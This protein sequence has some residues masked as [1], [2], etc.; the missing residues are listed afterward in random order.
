MIEIK[1]LAKAFA[2]G[3][4]SKLS[5]TEKQDVRYADK[6]F[7]SVRDVSFHCG[8][9]EV[10][11]LLGPNGAGK[12]T[13]LRMLSTALKPDA[14]SVLINGVDVLREPVKARKQIGFLSADTGL[15]GKLSAYENIAYF[16]RLHGMKEAALKQRIDELFTMLNMHDFASRRAD[17]MS[18][19]MKQKTAIARAVVHSP[20]VVILDEPT[21]GLD[22]MT[23]QTV[24]DFI[25]G[26]KQAGTPVIFSTHHLDEVASLCDRVVVIDKG[27]SAFSGDLAEFKALAP[28]GDLR[29]AFLSVLKQQPRE[30]GAA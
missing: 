16:G 20:K 3:K 1:N 26:L 30:Q 15:Y 24:L 6:E 27:I 23:V 18:T 25:K 5:E 17:N 14:G 13:T 12:T 28:A 7:R 2:L 4:G 9:G 10:L 22:I 21:T 29:D 19:G 11:G 8:Q